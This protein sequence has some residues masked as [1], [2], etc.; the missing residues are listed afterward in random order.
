MR[1]SIAAMIAL[2]LL[3]ASP[4]EYSNDFEKSEVGKVPDDLMVLDG[5]FAVRTI[6]GNKCLELAADPIG[7]FGVL[8][9]PAT[10]A[11]VGVQARVWSAATGKRLPEFGI[12]A[13]D[14]GGW[15]LWLVPAQHVI[16]L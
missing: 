16:E 1:S 11:T 9:G 14:A 15:K 2:A 13:G 6:E 10:S 3:A 5:S 4:M 12:G 8:F 7:T